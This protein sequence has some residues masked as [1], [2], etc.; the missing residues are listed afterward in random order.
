MRFVPLLAVLLAAVALPSVAGAQASGQDARR[1]PASPPSGA[2]PD[3]ESRWIFLRPEVDFGSQT[4]FS[5]ANVIVSR[6]F[7]TL[8]WTE[9]ERRLTEIEWQGGFETVWDALSDPSAAVERAGGWGSWLQK[10]MLPSGH[11]LSWAVASNMWGHVIA[12]GVSARHLA[13]WYEHHGVPASRLLGGLTVWGTNVLNETVEAANSNPYGPGP[14]SSV[15]DIYFWEPLGILLFNVDGVARLFRE[16]LSVADWS[17]QG[18]VVFPDL[19]IENQAQLMSY[20]IPLPLTEDWRPLVLVGQGNQYGIQWKGDGGLELAGAVGF[21]ASNRH[22]A[23]GTAYESISATWSAGTYVS[24]DD[25]LLGSLV[26]TRASRV[27]VQAN[28]YPGVLPGMF[29]DVG[30]WTSVTRSGAFSL[31]IAMRSTGGLGLGWHSPGLD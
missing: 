10:E 8:V 21:A 5:P 12:G 31:G 23:E 9:S 7:S 18:A 29:R 4:L 6:G 30:V 22:V 2:E 13:E 16:S 26:F 14:A 3:V 27:A 19:R 1:V 25:S 28:L 24:R 11:V 20:K 15:G 17:P